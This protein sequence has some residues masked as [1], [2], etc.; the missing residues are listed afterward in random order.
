M[1]LSCANFSDSLA[2]H[3]L[4]DHLRSDFSQ[5]KSHEEIE[6]Q[7]IM[8]E[9]LPRVPTGAKTTLKN[10]LHSDNR[11]VLTWW[12]RVLNLTCHDHTC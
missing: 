5:L 7:Y 9:L 2:Y 6:N 4:L 12:L 1:Q 10:D 8:R 3:C 11:H